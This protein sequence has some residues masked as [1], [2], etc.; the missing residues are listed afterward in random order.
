MASPSAPTAQQMQQQNFLA[1]QAVIGN[2][3]KMKQQIFSQAIDPTSQTVVNITGNSIR[4]VGLLLGFIVEVTG[5]VTNGA[6]TTATRTAF[7]NANMISQIRFDDLSNYTRIQVPGWYLALLNSVRQGFGYG[8]VYA[9]NIPMGYGDNFDVYQGDAT[10]AAAGTST[11]RMMYYVPIAYSSTDLRGAMCPPY[12]LPVICRLLFLPILLRAMATRLV[13]SIPETRR[14]HGPIL[15][16]LL[17][18][19]F[20]WIR[21]RA[22][23]MANPFCLCRI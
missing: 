2:S 6:G 12:P 16:P 18:I 13:L 1:R 14:A 21:C 17:F 10:I 23:R 4:N 3:I 9:N 15:S 11:L 19:R 22:C 20:I 5:G 7:G 8:G